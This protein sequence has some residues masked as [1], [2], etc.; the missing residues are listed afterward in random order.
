MSERLQF[1]LLAVLLAAVSFAAV[2][3]WVKLYVPTPLW[4]YHHRSEGW[5]AASCVL[6]VCMAAVAL[7]PSWGAAVGAAMFAGG[8]LGNVMSASAD[9]LYVPNP[10]LI[11]RTEGVAF[12]VADVWIVGGNITLMLACCALAIRNRER[13]EA[14]RSTARLRL[15]GR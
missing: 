13:I 10:L 7:L 15:R 12:N 8:L 14:W 11:G 2:D 9:H 3:Q 5:L 4:A 1:R 6:F